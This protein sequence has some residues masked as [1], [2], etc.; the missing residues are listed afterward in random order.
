MAAQTARATK[1]A[2]TAWRPCRFLATARLLPPAPVGSALS[3]QAS[4]HPA[5]LVCQA[6]GKSLY[7][8]QDVVRRVSIT[9]HSVSSEADGGVCEL[10]DEVEV[11]YTGT[12]DDGTPFDST[13]ARDSPLK[14]K[15][16]S[17]QVP[18]CLLNPPRPSV[19][20]SS[21]TSSTPSSSSS[22]CP[23]PSPCPA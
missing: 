23:P 12:L 21:S 3:F 7:R 5:G 15:I 8:S 16:G 17:G 6:Y 10:G 1:I 13:R 18:S 20:L 4:F 22:S 2:G 19:P 11:H 9:R 14:F